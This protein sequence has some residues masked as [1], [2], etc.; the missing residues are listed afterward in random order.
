VTIEFMTRRDAKLCLAT[1]FLAIA[2]W[3]IGVAGTFGPTVLVA[4]GIALF[5]V[6]CVTGY[7]WMAGTGG[8]PDD[9]RDPR[10]NPLRA[11]PDAVAFLRETSH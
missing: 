4:F 7:S 5:T 6:S 2:G 9:Y 1:W 11:I 10:A 8:L 3:L